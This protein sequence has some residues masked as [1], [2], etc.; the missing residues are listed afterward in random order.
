VLPRTALPT[1]DTAAGCDR[2]DLAKAVAAHYPDSAPL[3]VPMRCADSQLASVDA[4]LTDRSGVVALLERTGTGP[5][6]VFATYRPPVH[7]G[8]LDL[9]SR[10]KC[11][12]LHFDD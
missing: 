7:C 11:K 8:L 12:L 3:W 10:V 4:V 9:A 1:V 2:H 6:G 5:W